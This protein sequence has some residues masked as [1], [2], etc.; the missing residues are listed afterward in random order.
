MPLTVLL[1][2]HNKL[3]DLEMQPSLAGLVV[4]LGLKSDRIAIE[5][6]G[7]IVPR[8]LWA[9]TLLKEADRIELVHFVGGGA[10]VSEKSSFSQR[11][12]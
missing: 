12:P 1:N 5:H 4:S 3:C 2:G 11:S 7:A 10:P 6:N 9:Q 8:A